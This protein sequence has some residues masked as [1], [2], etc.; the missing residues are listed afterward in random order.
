MT[1]R[2]E[3]TV[4][5][6]DDDAEVR[7]SLRQLIESVGM[8]VQTFAEA[9]EFLDAYTPERPGCLVLDVRMPGMSG[10][11]LQRKLA[12]HDVTLPVIFISAHGDIPMAVNALKQGAVDFI[13]KPFRAQALLE[14]VSEA[15]RVDRRRREQR[16]SQGAVS[17]QLDRLTPREREVMQ[18]LVL[19]KSVKEVAVALD[20]SP[21]TV[22]IHRA[23]VMDKLDAA[24]V[25]D[26]VRIAMA[27]GEG[28]AQAAA[29]DNP[30]A[31]N[32]TNGA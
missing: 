28:W 15:I 26:L 9:Q 14:R 24:S 29:K 19:G 27:A 3:A 16:V 11:E 22:Q 5:V 12:E 6:V 18:L 1:E 2:G 20:I 25:V 8:P 30:V 21:K 23:N 31:K 32:E 13:E 10:L 7:K 4:F 17:R